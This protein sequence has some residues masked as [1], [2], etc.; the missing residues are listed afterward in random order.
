MFYFRT[1]TEYMMRVAVKEA[2]IFILMDTMKTWYEEKN[3]K[4][5]STEIDAS[6]IPG[7]GVNIIIDDEWTSNITKCNLSYEL[8]LHKVQ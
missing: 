8:N 7:R 6:Q 5:M 3:V 1:A 2:I 4:C